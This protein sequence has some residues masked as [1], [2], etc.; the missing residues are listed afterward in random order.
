MKQLILIILMVFITALSIAQK[1]VITHND[2]DRWMRIDKTTLSENGKILVYEVVPITP[3]A[4]G[5]SE[6]YNY[7][8]RNQLFITFSFPSI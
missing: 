7:Y 1:K 4:D 6:V 8:D 3:F 5:F 2:Y